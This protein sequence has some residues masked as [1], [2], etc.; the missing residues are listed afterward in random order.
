VQSKT[1]GS[2][3]N[4]EA[5]GALRLARERGRPTATVSLSL[6]SD[7]GPQ[8]AATTNIRHSTKGVLLMSEFI[9]GLT[10][11]ELFYKEAAKPILE[12]Y[13]PQVEYS[14]ALI[15]WGSEVLGYD[16][17]QSTDH[18]WGPRF[19]LFLSE[20]NRQQYEK[21][22]SAS[23]SEHLPYHFRGYSTN[24]G[25]E[26]AAKVR[27]PI[28]IETGPVNHMIHI[29]SVQSFFKWYLGCNPFDEVQPLDWLTF[30]EHKLLTITS[31]RVFHDGLGELEAVR[32]KFSYYPRDIWLYLL[33]S[34]WQKIA[35][36]EHFMGRCGS[37]EDE[38]GS[39][40]IAARLVH[41]LMRLCFLMQ[42]RYA[43]Y[44]KWFG[45]A[46]AELENAKDLS[47]ILRQVFL[48]NSWKERE[49]HLS[50]AYEVVA[51]L[52][53]SL[54]ITKPLETKVSP[55]YGRPTMVIHGDV[56]VEEIFDAIEREDIKALPV[57]SGSVNQFVDSTDILTRASLCSKL[58]ILWK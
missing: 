46:F 28:E 13:F 6:H 26:D 10:L 45:T 30:S 4:S 50:R 35:Q 5:I 48:A 49:Q 47:P 31:G 55:Y 14:A 19:L 7:I 58:K 56:F 16:D 43:P 22:I 57:V 53:N 24:F 39:Q 34:Q 23:L 42:K 29:E 52:H 33:G 21:A 17:L 37:L 40:L 32:Q 11:S 9:P 41:S 20:Q 12:T 15:G 2:E 54:R 25:P 51:E 8:V 44:S 18:H 38:I 27:L 36:E 1:L 3:R